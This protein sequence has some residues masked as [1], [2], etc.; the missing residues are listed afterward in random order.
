[1]C[2]REKGHDYRGG[3]SHERG[4]LGPLR[5]GQQQHGR[6]RRASRARERPRQRE[7]SAECEGPGVL[8]RPADVERTRVERRDDRPREGANAKRLC[9]AQPDDFPASVGKLGGHPDEREG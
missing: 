5:G 1:M 3:G 6:E 8:V 2:G 7:E 9:D 4:L